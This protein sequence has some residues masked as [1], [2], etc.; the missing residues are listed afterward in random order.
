MHIYI[1][2]YGDYTTLVN[3]LQADLVS[4]KLSSQF[5][6]HVIFVFTISSFHL[7]FTD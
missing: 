2:I 6:V 5:E 4:N 3:S 7:L 1:Q